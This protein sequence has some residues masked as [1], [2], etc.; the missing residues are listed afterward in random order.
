MLKIPLRV[1][2]PLFLMSLLLQPYRLLVWA[3]T[4]KDPARIR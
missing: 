3:V 4:G 2:V 1:L